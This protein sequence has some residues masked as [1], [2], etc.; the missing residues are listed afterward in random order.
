[1]LPA[2][3]AELQEARLG[4][5]A[6]IF[7]SLDAQRKAR[8]DLFKPVQD[9]IKANDLIRED[10]RLQ[11]QATLAASAETIGELLFARIKQTSGALRGQDEAL[12]TVKTLFNDHDLN[13][14]D[15]ALAFAKALHE[16][17]EQAA[18]SAGTE[19]G[20]AN[21]LKKEQSAVSVYDLIFGLEFLEPR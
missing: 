16:T 11:V 6:E 15:G 20:I 10:Y 9:L 5:T 17:V 21:I 2:K 3:R 19:V 1:E 13:N 18:K 4:L 12:S 8:E 7:D 14:K